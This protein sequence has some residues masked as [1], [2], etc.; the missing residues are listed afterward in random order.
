M[1]IKENHWLGHLEQSWVEVDGYIPQKGLDGK[2]I[3]REYSKEKTLPKELVDIARRKAMEYQ[4]MNPDRNVV[5]TY[6]DSSNYE[7]TTRNASL[8]LR[9]E[10]ITRGK[11]EGRYN[12]QPITTGDLNKLEYDVC[13]ELRARPVHIVENKPTKKEIKNQRKLKRKRR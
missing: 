10:K 4:I 3:Y 2:I 5:I 13:R 8:D 11:T 1:T 6:E 9:G 12:F 7:E